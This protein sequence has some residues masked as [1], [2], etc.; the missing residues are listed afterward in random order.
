MAKAKLTVLTDPLPIG[1]N[2]LPET[3][4]RIARV[5]KYSVMKRSFVSHPRF[6]GHF[7]VT[8]S[9]IEGLDKIGADFNYNPN[10]LADLATTVVVLAGVQTLR[11]AIKLKQKGYIKKLYAGPNLVNFSSDYDSLLASTEI[12]AAIT[13][14][15]LINNLYI[16]DNPSLKDRI[17]SWPAGVDTEYWKPD[18]NVKREK[19]LIFEK[20][21]KGPVG[22]ISPYVNYLRDCGWPVVI[23]KYG[24]YNHNEF[25][26]MLRQSFLML[27]FVTDESQGIAWLEAWSADVPTLIWKNNYNV[28]QGRRY[29]CST[30]PYLNK[31]NGLFFND[32]E[33]FKIK[34]DYWVKHR[35]QFNPRAWTLKNMSDEKCAQQL[36]KKVTTC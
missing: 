16:E 11:Q 3:I 28:I 8:R 6:R 35:E 15:N 29:K 1:L 7:A 36:Y 27:G 25:L 22:P 18:P 20:H 33:D 10:C 30:A 17:F 19:I 32:L 14:C 9:L 26:Q 4:R 23:I 5:L 13:P 34:F 24:S 31:S 21:A 2:F 12:D